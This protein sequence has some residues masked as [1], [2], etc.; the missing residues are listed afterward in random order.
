MHYVD[1]RTIS[2]I[3][4]KEIILNCINLFLQNI[5]FGYTYKLS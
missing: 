3:L 4:E 1:W 5:L 2:P